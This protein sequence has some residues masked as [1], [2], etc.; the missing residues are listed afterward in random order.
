MVIL[1]VRDDED[2]RPT[3]EVDPTSLRALAREAESTPARVAR[4]SSPVKRSELDAPTEANP[5][6][7]RELLAAEPR[8]TPAVVRRRSDET[9]GRPS[10]P[11]TAAPWP[12]STSQLPLFII[13]LALATLAA[14]IVLR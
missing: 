14:I 9:P 5:A 7:V 1:V 6:L 4:G 3:V 12:S 13:A 8:T 2:T 10:R 11:P